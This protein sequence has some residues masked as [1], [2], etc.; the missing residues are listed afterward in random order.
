MGE[1]RLEKKYLNIPNATVQPEMKLSKEERAEVIVK[2]RML[3][4]LKEIF[5]ELEKKQI[6]TGIPPLHADSAVTMVTM[7]QVCTASNFSMGS[8][9]RPDADRVEAFSQESSIYLLFV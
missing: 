7:Q 2:P 1:V 4:H 8:L 5:K 9:N 6:Y 3:L